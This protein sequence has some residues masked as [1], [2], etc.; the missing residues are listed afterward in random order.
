MYVAT[1]LKYQPITCYIDALKCHK[2]YPVINGTLHCGH[3][4]CPICYNDCHEH[5]HVQLVA[6]YRHGNTPTVRSPVAPRTFGGI[7]KLLLLFMCVHV[8]DY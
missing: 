3:H 6:S 1:L 8:W 2:R 7:R 4:K 5:E